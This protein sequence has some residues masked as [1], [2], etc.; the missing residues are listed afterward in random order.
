MASA[1][2]GLFKADYGLGVTGVAG[3]EMQ[4]GKPVGTVYIAIAG[5]QG[6][7][8]GRGPGWRGGREDQKR[9]A[10]LTALNLLRLH[11]EGLK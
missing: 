6:I 11:L 4:E 3:P 5:P 2:R 8:D 7:I 9:L 10:T 1:V